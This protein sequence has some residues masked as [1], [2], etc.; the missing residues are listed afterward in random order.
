MTTISLSY[1]E[2][3]AMARKTIEYILSLGIFK[4]EKVES[5]M[6]RKTLKAIRDAKEKKNITTCATFED[7]LKAVEE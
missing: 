4:E 2:K 1:N 5:P 7:Y 6:K 3:N